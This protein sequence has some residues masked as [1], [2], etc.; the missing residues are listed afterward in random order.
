[1]DGDPDRASAW[2]NALVRA[3]RDHLRLVVIDLE[4]GDNAQVILETLN[5]R[6]RRCWPLTW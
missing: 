3:L 5:H 6:A 4:R 1:M 2:L